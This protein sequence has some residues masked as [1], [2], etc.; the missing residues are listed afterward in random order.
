[1]FIALN[2]WKLKLKFP[3]LQK[4]YL[5]LQNYTKPAKTTRKDR[6]DWFY[7]RIITEMLDLANH[8]FTL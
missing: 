2:P 4:R 8:Q 7:L 3:N 5:C 6:L 1:M